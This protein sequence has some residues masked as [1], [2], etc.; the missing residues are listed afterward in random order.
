MIFLKFAQACRAPKYGALCTAHRGSAPTAARSSSRSRRI[1]TRPTPM[2]CGGRSPI[3]PT[4]SRTCMWC[5]TAPAGTDL[6]PTAAP[7]DSSMLIDA[8]RWKQ[9]FPC[10]SLC[11]PGE[12]L[13]SRPQDLGRTRPTGRCPAAAAVARLY[14]RRLERHLGD[15]CQARGHAG[16][17]RAARKPRTGRGLGG[18]RK[19]RCAMPTSRTRTGTSLAAVIVAPRYRQQLHAA[20]HNPSPLRTRN[21]SINSA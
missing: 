7:I 3:A 12:F 14:A 5:R 2:R 4:R 18:R 9:A 10:R 11:R 6:Q 13:D 1:S 17:N 8:Y 20:E 19:P 16:G 21:I 15:L